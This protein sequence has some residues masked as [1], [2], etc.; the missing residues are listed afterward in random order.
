MSKFLEKFII[1][2]F[3]VDGSTKKIKGID[4]WRK[5]NPWFGKNRDLTMQALIVIDRLK[6]EGIK[7][8]SPGFWY[9]FN[10]HVHSIQDSEYTPTIH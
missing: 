9:A 8:N 5:Q 6:D 3:N 4:E 2:T 1:E 10:V 7:P